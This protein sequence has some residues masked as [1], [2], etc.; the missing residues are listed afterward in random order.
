MFLTNWMTLPALTIRD[1]YKNRCGWNFS[2]SGSSSTSGS[3]PSTAPRNAV[4]TQIWIAKPVYVLAAVV[5]KRLKL[6]VSLYTSM[7]IFLVTV[8][9][10]ASISP[11]SRQAAGSSGDAVDDGQLNLS[12]Y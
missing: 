9:E 3:R 11:I 10:K 6:D 1:R 12:K 5:R 2:L 8:F 4:K 7:L